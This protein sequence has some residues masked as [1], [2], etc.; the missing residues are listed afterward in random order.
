MP[1]Y[2]ANIAS[3]KWSPNTITRYRREVERFAAMTGLDT[4]IRDVDK[5]HCRTFLDSFTN[6]SPNTIQLE[7][8]ILNSLFEFLVL[9]DAIDLNPMAK[10]PRPKSVDAQR[11]RV[12]TDEV[13]QMLAAC[14]TWPERVCLHI[15]AFTGARRH[16]VSELRW[17]DVDMTRGTVSFLEKGSKRIAKPIAAELRTVLDLYLLEHNVDP[18][19]FVI[20]NKRPL[21]KAER[22]DRIVYT[23][24]KE[25][26]GRCGVKAHAHALRAAFAVA[27]LEM[28][29]DRLMDLKELMGHASVATTQGSY[30]TEFNKAKAMRSVEGLSFTLEE[31]A[32]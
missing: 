2:F 11:T 13:R 21:K 28:H 27:F 1:G 4:P 18:G 5:H 15:L 16:A 10:V 17:R 9:D 12:T 8:T 31:P 24:V 30:L 20:P 7:W 3:R 6:H 26:A 19:D 32:A 29:P 23:L 22:S 14:E 25:V